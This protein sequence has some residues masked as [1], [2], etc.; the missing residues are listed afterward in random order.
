MRSRPGQGD[1]LGALA[2]PGQRELVR[3][4]AHLARG[5]ACGIACSLRLRRCGVE[6]LPFGFEIAHREPP[7]APAPHGASAVRCCDSVSVLDQLRQFG[8][9]PRAALRPIPACP[10]GSAAGRLARPPRGARDTANA[11]RPRAAVR[12]PAADRAAASICSLISALT[13]GQCF[14]LAAQRLD[15]ALAQ[16][17]ALL[18]LRRNGLRAPSPAPSHS[19][20]RVMTASSAASVAC[21]ARASIRSVRDADAARQLACGARVRAPS[22]ERV[23]RG[24]DIAA[25]AR[26]QREATLG[27]VR[28]TRIEQAFGRIDRGRFQQ[29]AQRTVSTAFPSPH[30]RPALRPGEWRDPARSPPAILAPRPSPGPAPRVA[31]PRATRAGRAPTVPACAVRPGRPATGAAAPAPSATPFLRSSS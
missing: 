27:E 22:G 30:P 8:V 13:P 7:R 6:L 12:P 26:E 24:I 29:R 25:V 17:T 14:D 18:A 1:H 3:G 19:P 10:A 31:G 9:D 21:R 2:F 20:L 23:R 5:V 15:L 4:V 16:Q 11:A 28:P